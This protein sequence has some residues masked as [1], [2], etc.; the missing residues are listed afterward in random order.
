MMTRKIILFI[1]ISIIYNNTSYGFMTKNYYT[2]L[3]EACENN[4]AY[5][6]NQY[7]TGAG[8]LLDT[9][10]LENCTKKQKVCYIEKFKDNTY[11]EISFDHNTNTLSTPKQPNIAAGTTV[12]AVWKS[13]YYIKYGDNDRQRIDCTQYPNQ[14]IEKM[15]KLTCS[16]GKTFSD[17]LITMKQ[18]T[19]SSNNTGGNLRVNDNILYNKFSAQYNLMHLEPRTTPCPKGH[20]C[21]EG[22]CFENKIKCPAGHTTLKE[23]A[24]S[25]SECTITDETQFCDNNGCFTIG[26]LN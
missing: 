11:I 2:D 6:D 5:K 24:T 4:I 10:Q 8:I 1:F 19:G 13:D 21:P 23:G 15:D 16:E 14:K 18:L 12:H 9:Y 7:S 22:N 17:Y 20:Y 26:D 3:G 25:E